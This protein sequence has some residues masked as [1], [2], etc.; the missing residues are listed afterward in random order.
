MLGVDVVDVARLERALARPGLAQRLVT[1]AELARAQ[2]RARPAEHLAGVLAAK[3][4]AMKALG[5]RSLPAWA[6]RIE[7]SRGREG[8]PLV[9]VAGRR[10]PVVLSVS[11]DGGV[12]LAAALRLARPPA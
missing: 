11:H 6:R 5:L 3:E 10:A 8:A 9:S 1:P 12:A 2:G 4:A 7:V